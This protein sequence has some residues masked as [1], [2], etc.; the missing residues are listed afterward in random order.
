M[1]QSR[2]RFTVI[3]LK[4]HTIEEFVEIV[5]SVLNKEEILR[6]MLLSLSLSRYLTTRV[7]TF[8]NVSELQD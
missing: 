3:H 5:V 4:P 8:E 2:T 6:M 1:C 7:R